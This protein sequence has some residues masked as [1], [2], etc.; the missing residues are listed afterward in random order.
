MI[1]IIDHLFDGTARQTVE[2]KQINIFLNLKCEFWTL[3]DNVHVAPL[4]SQVTR[5]LGVTK[6]YH[7]SVTIKNSLHLK[8]RRIL[9]NTVRHLFRKF[10]HEFSAD[11]LEQPPVQHC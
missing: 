8:I 1:I 9:G 10:V 3:L 5:C 11:K 6:L 2:S 4:H 7:R